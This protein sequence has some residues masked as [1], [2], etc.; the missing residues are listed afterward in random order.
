MNYDKIL[1]KLFQNKLGYINSNKI[2]LLEK[3][4]YPNIYNYINTKYDDSSTLTE[5]LVR[6]KYGINKRPVCPI[7]GKPVSFYNKKGIIYRKYCSSKCANNDSVVRN[8][9][10][11]TNIVRYGTA[12][13]VQNPSHLEKYR[14]KRLLTKQTDRT[15]NTKK[16]HHTLNSSNTEKTLQ[17]FFSVFYSIYNT[18]TQYKSSVY[19]WHCD[20]YIKELDL[21]IEYQGYY[22]HGN[23]P[24][25]IHNN[26]DKIHLNELKV[27][28][29]SYYD[30]HGYWPQPI[31][32]WTEKDVEKRKTAINNNLNFIEIYGRYIDYDILQKT[33]N[34]YVSKLKSGYTCI[35][36]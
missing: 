31:T 4:V 27:K 15:I 30:E 23:H 26:D 32:I 17:K 12:S 10:T 19:P 18:Y 6:M 25:N 28:Y 24:F 2:H 11:N 35:C 14:K 33:I 8:K 34:E 29:Q 1:P 9:I 22:T 21:Y 5:S 13:P 7:C 20:F 3:N 36:F 16:L